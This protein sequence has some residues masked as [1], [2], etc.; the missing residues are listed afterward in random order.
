M[1]NILVTGANGQLGSDLRSLSKDFKHKF[2]FTDIEDLD[3]TDDHSVQQYFE[4]KNITFCI[5]CSFCTK[6]DI[7]HE[8]LYFRTS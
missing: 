7:H 6:E 3:L 1:A 4:G 8:K 2:Y 5:N